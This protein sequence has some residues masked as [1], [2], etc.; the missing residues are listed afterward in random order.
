MLFKVAKRSGGNFTK[1]SVIAGPEIK[2]KET[3]ILT[4]F[5]SAWA[6]KHLWIKRKQF[7]LPRDTRKL[8]AKNMFLFYFFFSTRF[9]DSIA[10]NGGSGGGGDG[11][12]ESYTVPTLKQNYKHQFHIWNL[13]VLC[14]HI[15]I[16]SITLSNPSG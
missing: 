12:N 7:V 14:M 6:K 8:Q 2:K 11:W 5:I 3:N 10:S 1:A 13:N 9:W 4:E 15:I 16:N